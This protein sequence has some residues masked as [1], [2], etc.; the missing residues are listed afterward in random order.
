MNLP[1]LPSI[2]TRTLSGPAQKIL[3][4]N[5]PPALKTMAARAI[6]P[7]LRPGDA[8]TVVFLLS[9]TSDPSIADLARTTLSSLPLP[10][11]NG[12]LSSDLEPLVIAKLAELY[13][14]EAHVV[15]KLL[16]MPRIAA[17][18]VAEIA[19]SCDEAIT[20]V[21]AI[22][23]ERLLA[24]PVIIERLYLNKKTRMSTAD[25]IVEL[26]VRHRKE[27]NIPAYAEVAQALMS[28]LIPEPS[29]EPTPD[30][31]LFR[32]T[33]ELGESLSD[34]AKKGEVQ[35]V[36]DEGEEKIR[37]KFIPLWVKL[38]TMTIAQKIRAASLGSAAER[39]LL[40]REPNRVVAEAAIRSPLV[41]EPEIVAASASRLVSEDVL[42]IIGHSKE[43][44]RNH[45]VKVNL[46]MNPRTPFIIASKLVGHLRDNELRA[47]AKSKNVKGAIAKLARQQLQRKSS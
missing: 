27:L 40:M 6:A 10:I 42:R 7:G 35:E 9:Q 23:E 36:N 8:A 41:Q 16:A 38:G 5:A 19:G 26:A 21:I 24:H 20:E 37:D 15:E 3:D 29:P 44:T 47:I 11:L 17:S 30:D 32:E 46:V 2:D 4:A 34:D 31:L 14:G 1:A 13:A 22:N 45:Q 43:W 33:I 12:A 25:R 28:E 18:T 39:A